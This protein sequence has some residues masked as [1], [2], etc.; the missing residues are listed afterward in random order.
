MSTPST[1]AT[2]FSYPVVAGQ[3]AD[4]SMISPTDYG[5]I[6]I[7][8]KIT[9]LA[10]Y[11]RDTGLDTLGA[12][13]A[14]AS[15]NRR[16]GVLEGLEP[17]PGSVSMQVRIGAGTGLYY[18]IIEG[19]TQAV[20]CRE[21]TVVLDAPHAT[22]HRYDLIVARP[23]GAL[24][25]SVNRLVKSGAGV[26][27]ALSLPYEYREG[28]ELVVFKGTAAGSPTVPACALYDIPV[29]LVL[30]QPGAPGVI[31][32]ADL[33]DVRTLLEPLG[34]SWKWI[35]QVSRVDGATGSPFIVNSR[36]T[37]NIRMVSDLAVSDVGIWV[38]TFQIPAD[39]SLG[40]L[41][42]PC[43]MVTGGTASDPALRVVATVAS[44]N[45]ATGAVVEITVT[46]T[47]VDSAGAPVALA[48][49]KNVN[50]VV[51]FVPVV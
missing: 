24:Y 26:V 50:A 40:T 46:V 33:F 3:I 19:K 30:V 34:S 22:D 9:D 2:R 27:S 10:R 23:A 45:L 51:E 7:A 15:G 38:A 48:N 44:S 5:E 18:N 35:G 31:A 16:S 21:T 25:G 47:L 8:T 13:Y 4:P 37:Q 28:I 29:A 41:R 43:V 6:P 49:L 36:N 11:Q 20:V 17:E 14:G 32:G 42:A 1:L 12:I 39:F